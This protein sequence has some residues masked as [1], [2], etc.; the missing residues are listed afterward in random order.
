MIAVLFVGVVL[1]FSSG[2][3]FG[4]GSRY[5]VALEL[6]VPL[7]AAVGLASLLFPSCARLRQR[8]LPNKY[9]TCTVANNSDQNQG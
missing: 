2:L 9:L 4:A 5:R 7:F 6:A 8:K 3:C 1:T